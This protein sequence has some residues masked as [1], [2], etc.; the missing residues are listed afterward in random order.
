MFEVA[1]PVLEQLHQEA[2]GV[3]ALDRKPVAVEAQEY[4]GGEEGDTLV[5]VNER[6]V[7]D[8][9]SNMAAAMSM[10]LW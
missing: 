6:V 10:R 8:S 4:I 3:V 5:A 9:D 2:V 7:V 1:L